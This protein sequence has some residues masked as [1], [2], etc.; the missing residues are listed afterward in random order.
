MRGDVEDP[1]GELAQV[2]AVVEVHLDGAVV[3]GAVAE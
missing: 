2:D 3:L 1:D